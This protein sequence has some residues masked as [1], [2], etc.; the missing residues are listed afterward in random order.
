MKSGT[1]TQIYI[2]LVFAV[3]NREAVIQPNIQNEVFSFITGTINSMG[4]KALAVNGLADHVHILVGL[5]PKM[6]VSDL[7][8]EVKRSSTNF[9]NQKNWMPGKFQWQPGFGG[10]SYSRSQIDQVINYIRNQK[11]HHKKKTFKEEYLKFLEEYKV[12]FNPD[13]LFKFL[14]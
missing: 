6:A 9:I 11:I 3:K 8:K 1:Y 13:F 14:D 7:V 10:F 12:G 2:Q 5:H 4:H